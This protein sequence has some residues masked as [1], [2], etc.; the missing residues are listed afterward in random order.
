M[1]ITAVVPAAVS[2]IGILL[3]ALGPERMKPPALHAFWCG[4]LV[5]LFTV[6]GHVWKVG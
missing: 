1:T 4:L 5:Y 3:W 6:A 2:L